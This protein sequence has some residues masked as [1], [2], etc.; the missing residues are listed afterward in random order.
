MHI[1]LCEHYLAALESGRLEDVMALFTTD[2]IVDSPLYGE[3]PA[4]PFYAGLFADTRSSENRLINI[5]ST[6]DDQHSVA[7]HFAYTWTLRNG[8]R[9]EFECVD[10]FDI[11]P[12]EDKFTRL[13]IIYDTAAIRPEFEQS[14]KTE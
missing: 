12:N 2:A 4:A 14:R 7:L 10:V 9:V 6:D 1:Q 11:A 5:Y 8:K 13:K 3:V